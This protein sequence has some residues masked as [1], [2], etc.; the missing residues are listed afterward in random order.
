MHRWK[1]R[2][3]SFTAFLIVLYASYFLILL[4][5]PYV[6]G[7]SH[8][9]FLRT[10][11]LIYH[12]T[13]WRYSFYIHVFASPIVILAGLFQFNRWVLANWPKVH[14]F[15]GYCYTFCILIITGPAAF[16]MSLWANGGYPSQISFV[17]LST[18][19]IF[20][21]YMAFYQIRKGNT[22][23]HLIWNIRSF[24]LTL[25][26][27]T[28]RFY[29][30]L[31]NYFGTEMGQVETYILVSYLSWIPNLIIAEILIRQRYPEYLMNYRTLIR[32]N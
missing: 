10:K 12:I 16:I 22:R 4:S 13:P 25:S 21:T 24:A 9:D 15:S 28:L 32:R 30:Y 20:C 31:F 18:L 17:A 29:V 19:W 3:L 8:T 1:Q 26:A 11:Q 27:I 14:R 2:I 23:S 6:N 7:T 5:L